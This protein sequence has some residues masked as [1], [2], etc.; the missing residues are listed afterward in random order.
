MWSAVSQLVAGV[1]AILTCPGHP[2]VRFPPLVNPVP[3]YDARLLPVLARD[4]A[5]AMTVS[6]VIFYM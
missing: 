1:W 5:L 6:D 4:V 2:P 3:A